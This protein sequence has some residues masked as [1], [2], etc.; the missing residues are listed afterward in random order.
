GAAPGRVLDDG[1]W[2]FDAA[3][4]VG[5][6]SGRAGC[7][8]SQRGVLEAGLGGARG[9]LRV[10]ARQREA[11]EAGPQPQDRRLGCSLAV[12]AAR[13]GGAARPL[14]AAATDPGAAPAPPP[15]PNTHP[16]A[17]TGNQ[18]PR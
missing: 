9:P 3:R 17:P 8:G 1:A 13:G 16:R 12:S 5:G 15:P 7:D 18:P 11:R 2:A 6:P 14:P 4:L 10:H